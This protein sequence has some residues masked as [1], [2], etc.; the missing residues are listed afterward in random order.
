MLIPQSFH[1]LKSWSL[2]LCHKNTA[3]VE[4][5]AASWKLQSLPRRA[6]L[7]PGIIARFKLDDYQTFQESS[8]W[9]HQQS[10]CTRAVC[11]FPSRRSHVT[12]S[13]ASSQLAD[14]NGKSTQSFLLHKQKTSS[15]LI[16]RL[17]GEPIT[18]T[19]FSRYRYWL[20]KSSTVWIPETTGLATQ[21]SAN[22]FS[23]AGLA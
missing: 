14:L 10:R 1:S 13:V 23:Q 4:R 8:R 20:S 16:K 2:S 12:G 6:L 5:T 18:L 9:L 15:Q 21:S 19:G 3:H 17:C 11:W 22:P 7:A